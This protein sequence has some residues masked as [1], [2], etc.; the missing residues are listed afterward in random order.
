[1]RRW[2]LFAFVNLLFALVVPASALAASADFTSGVASG[3]V[4][5]TKAILWTRAVPIGPATNIKVEVW[6]DDV[7]LT[8]PKSYQK[9][10]I[11]MSAARDYTIKVDASGLEPNTEFC[12]RFRRGDEAASP[13]GRFKTAPDPSSPADIHFTYT[14]DSDG[15]KVGGVPAFNNFEVLG[16]A[17]QANGDF[18]AYIGD[19]IYADSEVG[20]ISPARTL[21]DFR[22]KYRENRTYSNLTDLL[23]S[24]STYALADDHEVT[25]DYDGQ[26]VDPAL[27][28]AGR[29]AFLEYMPVRET[30]LLHDSSCAGDPLYRH[31]K[32]GSDVEIFAP[33][34]RSCRSGDVSSICHGD[35]GPTLPTSLRQSSPFSIFL[36]P[37]PPAGCLDAIFDPSRT[38]LGPVQKAHLEQDLMNSSAKFKYILNEYGIQQFHALPYDRWEGYGAERNELLSFIRDNVSGHVVFLT[39]DHHAT[40][41]NQVFIDRFENGLDPPTTIANEFITGPIATNT[42]QT[43]IVRV[44]GNI[45]LLAFN[46]VLAVDQLDCRN[47]NLDSWGD[48]RYSSGTQTSEIDSKDPTGALVHDQAIA[49]ITCSKTLP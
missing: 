37:T 7:C 17:R 25:N 42:L 23:A 18:F 39:T 21:D 38:V 29:E 35:L 43:E 22:A 10:N 9:S 15:V 14:A 27:Y 46:A 4:T 36:T 24:T 45:G 16:Q 49:S 8:G 40:M 20:G 6:K 13:V 44:V 1:M 33:D 2:W 12:Y 47:L 41:Q 30:G 34:E 19:T 48:V 31:F 28:A 32:W 3:D 5:P 26:T 11:P